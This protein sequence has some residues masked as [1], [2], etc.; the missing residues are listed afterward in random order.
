MTEVMK[1]NLRAKKANS[2]C[3]YCACFANRVSRPDA[4]RP[5]R[6]EPGCFELILPRIIALRF[7]L[8]S[9]LQPMVR[10]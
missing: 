8:A 6:K 7:W 9:W 4:G 10:P 1:M 3:I 5:G 2:F